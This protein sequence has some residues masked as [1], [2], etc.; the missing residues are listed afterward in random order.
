MCPRLHTEHILAIAPRPLPAA[1]V[2]CAQLSELHRSG[3]QTCEQV[4]QLAADGKKLKKA[5][6][7]LQA[8][9]EVRA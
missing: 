8:Q 1:C 2:P 9:T 5:L 7:R 4:E 6:G 3:A